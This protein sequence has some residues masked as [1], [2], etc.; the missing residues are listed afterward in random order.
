MKKIL[1]YLVIILIPLVLILTS[2]R[3]LLTPQ[4]VTVE[5]HLPGFPADD[6]GM[7]QQQ[8]LEYAPL[9]L[10]YLLNDQGIEFLGDQHFPDGSPL[11]NERELS[12]MAD[13]KTLTQ[14]LLKVWLLATAL[15]VG[16]AAAAWHF[17]WWDAFRG[18]L[19]RGGRVTVFLILI[20]LAFIFISFDA[21][22]VEFH[23][24]FFQGDSWLFLYSDTL[25][26]LFPMRFWQDV[27]IAL[28]AFALLGG[29]A[30][31]RFAAPRP[32]AK[33]AKRAKKK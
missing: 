2:V 14:T 22:F 32:Q 11:Y 4:F 7:T 33:A 15:L 3:L 6:Y 31:W 20:L 29:A 12:H 13:V 24:I 30:L 16:I 8:R 23:H 9:A 19:A 17:E 26:R 5:Y 28:A 21:L 10:D 1:G 27:F 25:I 18:W